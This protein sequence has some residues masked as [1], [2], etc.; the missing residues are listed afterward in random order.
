MTAL[1]VSRPFE[2]F[3]L[4]LLA[5]FWGSSYLFIKVALETIPPVT[6]IAFRV[7]LAAL[8]LYSVARGQ[9]HRMPTDAQ[10]W[11]GFGVQC[12]FL[13]IGGW[14]VLAWGQ[15]FIDSGLAGILNSTSPIFVFFITLLWTRH[16]S[17][18]GLRLFGALLGLAG[19]VFIIGAD[20]LR[21][22][23]T[24]VAGQ[25]A[26]LASAALYGGSAIYGKRFSE[27]PPTVTAAGTLT[28]ATLILVPASVLID[29]PWTLSP[30]LTSTGAAVALSVIS[31][32]L[33][34]L[35]YFRLIKTLGSM[36]TASQAYLRVGVSVLLGAAVL[37]EQIGWTVAFGLAAVVGG[38][39]AI[40]AR[41]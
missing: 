41:S 31:S 27:L 17:V 18:G 6:L 11:R 4:A 29:R 39:I 21:G 24:Q 36:G 32:C 5:V 9:G 33:A 26:V 13:C 37:G 20:A 40:N 34:L 19:V 28:V 23:G 2:L 38:V 7:S 25:I 10:T 12:F 3:L 35:L 15:Q 14:V 22:L 8:L 1:T 16:E 30:S